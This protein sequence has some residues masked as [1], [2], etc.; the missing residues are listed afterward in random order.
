MRQSKEYQRKLKQHLKPALQ[1]SHQYAGG[2][3]FIVTLS[4]PSFKFW[5]GFLPHK[6]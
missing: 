1:N 6:K 4:L 3:P 5:C 2:Y